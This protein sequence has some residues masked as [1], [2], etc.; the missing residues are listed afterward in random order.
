MNPK[1]VVL[2][3]R[4]MIGNTVVRYFNSQKLDVFEINREGI[5]V[6][7]KNKVLKFD[8]LQNSVREIIQTIKP[9]STI[10][11]LI[12]LIRHKI[13]TNDERSLAEASAVNSFFPLELVKLSDEKGCRV[14]QVATDCVFSGLTGSYRE[15]SIPDPID[16]YGISKLT[17]EIKA[18][19]L[20][21]LRVSVIGHELSNHVELLD[22]V[23]NQPAKSKISGYTNHIWNGITSLSLA[24]ILKAE[25]QN[26]TY[27][28][29]TFHIV[30]QDQTD[31]F[32]LIKD[33]ALIG[34]RA[35][36]L[37]KKTVDSQF[38]NRT[39]LTDFEVKNHEIWEKAG[40][41][42]IPSISMMLQE[43]FEWEYALA[44]GK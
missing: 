4:G 7:P 2:G 38:T 16:F 30:P 11:N 3:S 39:L 41:S 34:G 26:P 10:I 24:R 35:D 43:Y 20:L 32:R 31:K 29:G 19:N 1:I 12:G 37:I 42:I 25:I 40:Y 9:E 13:D 6:S 8:V 28:S 27:N 33:I 14:I 5:G 17:G 44:Q 36:I 22:W 15:S 23:L 18:K 21:T